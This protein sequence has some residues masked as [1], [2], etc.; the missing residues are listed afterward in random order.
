MDEAM[1]AKVFQQAM[2][3]FIIPEINNVDT[4]IIINPIYKSVLLLM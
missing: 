3:I 2:D 1:G 4:L